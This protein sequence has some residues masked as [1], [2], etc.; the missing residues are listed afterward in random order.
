MRKWESEASRLMDEKKPRNPD[1]V[2]T[3]QSRPVF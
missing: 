3:W 1:C 2:K